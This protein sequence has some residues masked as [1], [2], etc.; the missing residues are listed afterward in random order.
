[1]NTI[2]ANNKKHQEALD[3]TT[4]FIKAGGKVTKAP[5]DYKGLTWEAPKPRRLVIHNKNKI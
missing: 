2:Q 1:M 4:K 3:V 5:D